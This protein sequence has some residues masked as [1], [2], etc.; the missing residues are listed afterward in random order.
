MSWQFPSGGQSVGGLK[1]QQRILTGQ[2]SDLRRLWGT[3]SRVSSSCW[4]PQLFL[5]LW[6]RRSGLRLPNLSHGPPFFLDNLPLP[7][8]YQDFVMGFRAPQKSRI[9]SPQTLNL[10]YICKDSFPPKVHIHRSQDMDRSFVGGPPFNSLQVS[11][12]TINLCPCNPL[13]LNILT[14]EMGTESL[15]F[16]SHGFAETYTFP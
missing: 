2:E 5:N 12:S 16:L 14:C 6:S 7:H 11:L 4:W 1:Q 8:S 15:T 13:S 3:L 10:N 9:I